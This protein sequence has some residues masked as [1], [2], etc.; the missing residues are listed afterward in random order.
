M[1]QVL[2]VEDDPQVARI[3]GDFLEQSG[4][5]IAGIAGNAE[6]ALSCLRRCEVQLVLLDI[7]LPGSSGLEILRK[8]RMEQ[9]RIEAIIISAAKD[10]ERI[11]EAFSMG[12]VDYIIKPFTYA[13]LT[14]SL[15]R[16]QERCEL[17]GK[18]SLD[19][20]EVDRL[21]GPKQALGNHIEPSFPK[22]IDKTTL[23]RIASQLVDRRE[24]FCVQELAEQMELSRVSV[25]KYLDYLA[26]EKL[27]K[28]T[29]IY[30]GVGRPL[31]EYRLVQEPAAMRRMSELKALGFT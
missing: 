11:R 22:G 21:S 12:C 29:Y 3:T 1:Y 23:Q 18:Q 6:D 4:Y 20:S 7:Y 16:F 13:R 30:G 26:E 28:K 9:A 8:L 5:R 25:K 14:E 27:L 31:N 24:A 2:I 17:L 10:G 15:H 19:Q